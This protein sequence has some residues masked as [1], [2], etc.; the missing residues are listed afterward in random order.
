MNPVSPGIQ[1][2]RNN[3]WYKVENINKERPVS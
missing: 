2:R 3:G 1:Q